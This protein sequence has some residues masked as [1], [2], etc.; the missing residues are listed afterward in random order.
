MKPTERIGHTYG[1]YT[2]LGIAARRNGSNYFV[3]ACAHCGIDHLVRLPKLFAPPTR[4]RYLSVH[5]NHMTAHPLYRT[6]KTMRTRCNN[7]NRKSYTDYGGRGIGVCQRWDD[8][9][10]FVEDVGERPAGQTLDRIDTN[11]NYEPGNVRWATR[12]EQ[13]ANR[14]LNQKFTITETGG[15]T[16]IETGATFQS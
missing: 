14:R 6:W 5:G 9:R 16:A 3:C 10:R 13:Q 15:L 1:P 7:P 8:F 4:C 12:K 11:G 2:V